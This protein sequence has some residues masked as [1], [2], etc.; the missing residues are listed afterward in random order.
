MSLDSDIRELCNAG[1][2]IPKLYMPADSITATRSLRCCLRQNGLLGA[3]YVVYRLNTEWLTEAWPL[4][5]YLTVLQAE[6]DAIGKP[7][8]TEYYQH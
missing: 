3:I 7:M 1:L 5:S 6:L 8:Q 2:N 4:G